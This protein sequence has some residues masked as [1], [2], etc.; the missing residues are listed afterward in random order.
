MAESNSGIPPQQNMPS[1]KIALLAITE[2]GKKLADIICRDCK[3]DIF[4]CR[5][6]L[7]ETVHTTWQQYDQLV[8]IMATGIVIR[9][10]APLLDNKHHDPA[11]VVCDEKGDFAISMLSGHLGGG[12]EL[13]CEIAKRIKGSPII[14]TAS[15]V[16]GHT[17]IDLWA[18]DMDLTVS[19]GAALTRV[20]GKLVNNGQV[21]FSSDYPLPEVPP[22]FEPVDCI[23]QA[24]IIISP[25]TE[26]QTE[27]VVLHPRTLVAG[28]GCN[29][30]TPAA[31][32]VAA[33]TATCARHQLAL[34]SI[35]NLASIDVKNDEQGLLE[36]ASDKGYT[37]DFFN[38]DQLNG[39]EN[40]S[41][42]EAVLKAVGAKGV[43]EP[44][45]LLSANSTILRVRKEKWTDVT[46]AI[47][48]DPSPW[49]A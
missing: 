19:D 34:A 2:G 43:A 25:N 4:F 22:D 12:N 42:S 33:L 44:A 7:K 18:R 11:V 38:R 47:A 9:V 20:M 29:R 23:S 27:G 46:V 32:I 49:S 45:A 3:A 40:V 21:F 17:A 30:G 6:K 48:E 1:K 28:I 36:F 31:S 8:F 10:I 35:R 37:I 13:A 14:T 16:Q 39:V 5:G 15:D 26:I 41:S 24:D